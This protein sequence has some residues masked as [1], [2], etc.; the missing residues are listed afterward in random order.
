MRYEL[1]EARSAAS[2]GHTRGTTTG[3]MGS[4]PGT[5]SRNLGDEIQRKLVDMQRRQD[6]H[7]DGEAEK[8]D[9]IEEEVEEGDSYEE[10]VITTQRT[11]VSGPI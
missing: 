8:N 9:I 10:T 3:T 2:G 5:L 7:Q 6:S 4:V 11:R 1:D